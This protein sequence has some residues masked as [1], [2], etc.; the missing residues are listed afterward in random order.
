MRWRGE[1]G[2]LKQTSSLDRKQAIRLP[3]LICITSAGK[4]NISMCFNAVLRELPVFYYLI[5]LQ[6]LEHWFMLSANFI[7]EKKNN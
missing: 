6:L 4:V 1:G 3:R 2:T 5:M 7:D